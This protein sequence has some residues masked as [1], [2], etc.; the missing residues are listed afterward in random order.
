MWK[1]AH[2]TLGVVFAPARD[3][4]YVG[5]LTTSLA[6]F[7]QPSVGPARRPLRVRQAPS[8]PV[9]VASRSHDTPQTEAYLR[10]MGVMER[11]SIGSSLKFCLLAAG[12]ADLYPRPAPTCEWDTA[13]GHA[14]LSAAG[15]AV[16]DL[17][18]APFRYGKDRFFNPGFLA[19]GSLRDVPA[20]ASSSAAEEGAA[21]MS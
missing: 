12:L 21:P 8:P 4:L 5:D 18:G 6:E 9:A 20:L 14:V 19:V 1:S 3:E 7:G 11:T 2:P 10:R 15:G 13:A 17:E 16:Y